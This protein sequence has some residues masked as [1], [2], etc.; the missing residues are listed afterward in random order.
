[1]TLMQNTLKHKKPFSNHVLITC[2]SRRKQISVKIL[3]I[4]APVSST[5][6]IACIFLFHPAGDVTRVFVVPREVTGKEWVAGMPG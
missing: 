3:R 1:M 5:F 4:F 6:T 2:Q